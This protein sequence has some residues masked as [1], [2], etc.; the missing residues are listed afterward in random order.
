MWSLEEGALDR[1]GSR[2]SMT[3]GAVVLVRCGMHRVSGRF[4]RH[5]TGGRTPTVAAGMAARSTTLL[6]LPD[7]K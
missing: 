1:R 7:V 5:P 4:D 3:A 2:E 6:A